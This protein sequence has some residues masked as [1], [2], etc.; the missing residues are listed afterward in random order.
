MK[1]MMKGKIKIQVLLIICT[2]C[3][4]NMR[5]TVESVHFWFIFDSNRSGRSYI[6]SWSRLLWHP[7]SI[8]QHRNHMYLNHLSN[9]I[10]MTQMM[11]SSS[12]NEQNFSKWE[13]RSLKSL[14][15]FLLNHSFS[16][17]Y[18]ANKSIDD[19]IC[20]HLAY[21]SEEFICKVDG[22]IKREI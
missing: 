17:K 4:Y 1:S 8:N 19:G 15:L 12:M 2:I 9:D 16:K 11:M 3:F 22:N 5:P 20:H 14:F 10:S 18:L 21:F 13:I 7:Q 6:Y